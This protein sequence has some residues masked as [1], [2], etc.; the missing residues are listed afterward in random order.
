[1]ALEAGV[2]QDADTF[3]GLI[4]VNH[5]PA[6]ELARLPGFD[7]TLAAKIVEVREEIGGFDSV[8]DFATV[9]DLPPDLMP[10]VRERA[11]CLPR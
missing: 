2:G 11:V 8:L 6:E 7:E 4:D 3:G 5:A 9:L 10:A 1:M